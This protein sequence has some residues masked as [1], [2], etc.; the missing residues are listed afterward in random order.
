MYLYIYICMSI[1]LVEIKNLNLDLVTLLW[2]EDQMNWKCEKF[3]MK[4]TITLSW[5]RYGSF[6]F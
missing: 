1:W 2:P 5:F 6:S 3:K 4:G